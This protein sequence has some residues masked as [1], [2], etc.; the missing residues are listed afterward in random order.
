MDE[1]RLKEKCYFGGECHADFP[2]DGLDGS[3]FTPKGF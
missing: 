1:C 2:S 3:C